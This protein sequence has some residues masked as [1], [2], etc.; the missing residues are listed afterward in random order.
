MELGSL[1]LISV[2]KDGLFLCV[3]LYTEHVYKG[4]VT[5]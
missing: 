5:N 3:N 1:I 4:D 2:Q